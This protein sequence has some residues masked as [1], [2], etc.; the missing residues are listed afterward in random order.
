M[1]SRLD[2]RL[3]RRFIPVLLVALSLGCEVDP[4][5]RYL[6]LIAA[7]FL[8]SAVGEVIF[9]RTQIPD[10]VWLILAGVGLNVT[11]LIDPSNLD[12]IL[13]LFSALTL[14]IV[15]FDGGRQ[16]VI[17]DL[18]K[19][20]PKA[21]AM[22]FLSFILSVCGVA[23]IL[24]L[25]ALT[26]LL[27][28]SW[29][30]LHSLMVGAMLGGSSSLIIMPSMNLAKVEGKVSNLVGLESALTDALC[31]VVA[32]VLMNIITSGETN[33]GQAALVLGKNFG[34]AL[35][36]GLIAGWV[37]MPVLRTLS[38]NPY[39]YPITLA[40]LMI[41]YVFVDNTGGNPA[42]AVLTFSVIVGNA[43]ALMK[44]MKFSLGDKPLELDD[45]VVTVHSQAAFIIKS[46]FFT[47]IGLMLSRPVSLLLLGMVVGISLFVTRIPA[48][49]L[50]ARKGFTDSQRKMVTIS[51]PRGMAAGVLATLPASAKYQIEGTEDLP[52]M[53]FAAVVTSIAIFAYGFRKVR[54]EAP[55]E[56]GESVEAGAAVELVD[57]AAD[58]S[59]T[60]EPAQAQRPAIATAMPDGAVSP[61]A[62]LPPAPTDEPSAPGLAV[63]PGLMLDGRPAAELASEPGAEQPSP[64]PASRSGTAYGIAPAP[65]EPKP[66]SEAKMPTA[67]GI[68]M[69]TML[70]LPAAPGG[71]P[72]PEARPQIGASVMPPTA[73]KQPEPPVASPPTEAERAPSVT[74]RPAPQWQPPQPVNTPQAPPDASAADSEPEED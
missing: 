5:G 11:G 22:A 32:V 34:F 40:A 70:G 15:L 65:I 31:V 41:L 44:M 33:G 17:H 63:D 60:P 1:D 59:A 37:W 56:V 14:I 20:A 53:V 62:Q 74:P 51:L 72:P 43:E 36:I 26:G 39:A 73:V 61:T 24:Q 50:V 47:Y 27:P 25:A 28:A 8:L 9:A 57:A 71:P 64:A 49:M 29:T 6:V 16:I 7:L 13:P 46:F 58:G 30:F 55:A 2:G 48:V 21:S 23:V 45:A 69:Q 38:G 67:P 68:P 42:M 18:I 66:P 10:V 12:P 19:A 35:V 54:S 3:V 52:S 4:T